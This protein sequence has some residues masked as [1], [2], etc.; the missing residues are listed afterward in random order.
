MNIKNTDITRQNFCQIINTNGYKI[1]V[2]IGVAKGDYSAYILS[3]SNLTKLYCID[4]F[5]SGSSIGW[6]C[7][8][9]VTEAR[10]SE[11]KE[12]AVVIP[13]TSEDAVPAFE[14]GS[15]DFIYIDGDHRAEAVKKDLNLWYPKLKIGGFFSGH[16]YYPGGQQD[17]V[18]QVNLFCKTNNITELSLSSLSGAE[19]HIS[20]KEGG[21]RSWFFIKEKEMVVVENKSI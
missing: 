19:E 13:K 10:L 3:N 14:N 6:Y 4:P 15:I 8:V 5:V 21:A 9:G 1:G 16:D 12:R 18:D 7:N 20:G 11:F 2:E 17:V